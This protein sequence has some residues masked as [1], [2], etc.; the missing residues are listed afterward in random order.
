MLSDVADRDDCT[1]SLSTNRKRAAR[2]RVCRRV[3]APCGKQ[4]LR[5]SIALPGRMFGAQ[6]LLV[7]RERLPVQR[8]G[9]GVVPFS[10]KQQRGFPWPS[11][12]GMFGAQRLLINQRAR[13]R[14]APLPRS[15][16]RRQARRQLFSD[17]AVVGW[18][19]PR[20]FSAMTSV[21]DTSA[22]LRNSRLSPKQLS[23]DCPSETAVL[24]CSG[25][26]ISS[27]YPRSAGRA[28][29]RQHSL[30]PPTTSLPGC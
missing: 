21:Y 19:G 22:P 15:F 4:R 12:V 20:A 27:G 17:D 30:L 6:N 9:F 14:V 24:E 25:P 2:Q 18:S 5:V 1:Q 8:L 23:Q 10:A 13:R 7:N 26:R 11:C 3:L 16:L 29:P 28:I